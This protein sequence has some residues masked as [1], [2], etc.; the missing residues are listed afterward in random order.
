MPLAEATPAIAAA[1]RPLVGVVAACLPARNWNAW[2]GRV[3]VRAMVLPAALLTF[4]AGFA[5]GIP[6]FLAYSQSMGSQVGGLVLQ[7]GHEVNAGRMP[8]EAPAIAWFSM[9][10]ALPAFAFF[11][12]TGLLATYLV[13]SGIFRLL[14]WGAGEPRGDPLLSVADGLVRDRLAERKL[15]RGQEARNALE[16]PEVPDLL[17]SGLAMGV[18]EAVYAVV[19]SRLKPG[20]DPGVFVLT[21]NGRFRIGERRDRRHRDG[22]RAVYPLL[23]V[24]AVEATRR[25]VT[26]TLPPLSE[27]DGV[28]QRV[29][30]P[31]E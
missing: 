27:W 15:R 30:S 5:I 16:G 2:D 19:A 20:W 24:P 25:R 1:L 3:P 7:S 17:V 4:F 12:P 23:E 26:Y 28:S 9:V 29:R 21:E 6:G 14:C 22:L 18:P 10:I 31:A 8:G 11:T 13:G